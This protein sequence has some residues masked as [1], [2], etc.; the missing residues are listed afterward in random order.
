MYDEDE[1][2]H[3]YHLDHIDWNIPDEAVL[4]SDR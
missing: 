4:N 3:L 1:Y 2:K